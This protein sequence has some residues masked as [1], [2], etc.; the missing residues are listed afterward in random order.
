ML[1]YAKNTECIYQLRS[2][3][4][5]NL[6]ILGNTNGPK[7][8]HTDDV[9]TLVY[10]SFSKVSIQLFASK[11]M[12]STRAISLKHLPSSSTSERVNT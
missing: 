12:D 4:S 10:Y 7:D 3:R 6:S 5:M 1:R 11:S 2:H 9:R 8:D